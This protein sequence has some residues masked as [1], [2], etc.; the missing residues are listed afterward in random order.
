MP[1]VVRVLVLETVSI[2]G[3]E[4][5][6]KAV[7]LIHHRY[8]SFV[9]DGVQV[10]HRRLVIVRIEPKVHCYPSNCR[11]ACSGSIRNVAASW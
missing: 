9:E 5:S 1:S 3:L 6:D 7:H 8:I 4:A 2:S 10:R 11:S